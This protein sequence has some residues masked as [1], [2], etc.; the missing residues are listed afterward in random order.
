MALPEPQLFSLC[1]SANAKPVMAQGRY[2]CIAS[3]LL[4]LRSLC[5]HRVRQKQLQQSSD[6]PA[7]A[8]W[9][10]ERGNKCQ[11]KEIASQTLCAGH[12]LVGKGWQVPPIYSME[13]GNMMGFFPMCY[14]SA[15]TKLP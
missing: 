4:L 8:S 1:H 9:R 10:D 14:A 13:D 2:Y 11:E 15:Q 7:I 12:L 6:G 3:C 5:W